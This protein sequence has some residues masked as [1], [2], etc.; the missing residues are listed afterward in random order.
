MKI[1]KSFFFILVSIYV[2]VNV[3]GTVFDIDTVVGLMDS[4]NDSFGI[5]KALNENGSDEKGVTCEHLNIKNCYNK[6]LSFY[7]N[8]YKN[9]ILGVFDK[10]IMAL[11]D[12]YNVLVIKLVSQYFKAENEIPIIDHIMFEDSM[13]FCVLGFFSGFNIDLNNKLTDYIFFTKLKMIVEVHKNN[14]KEIVEIHFKNR[15]YDE[16]LTGKTIALNTSFEN[17]TTT[18]LPELKKKINA[19]SKP[20]C[21]I[22]SLWINA[23]S[24]IWTKL[25]DTPIILTKIG[26][27]E[28]LLAWEDLMVADT[29]NISDPDS[30]MKYIYNYNWISVINLLDEDFSER[31]RDL[32]QYILDHT[33][34]DTRIDDSSTITHQPEPLKIHATTTGM[35]ESSTVTHKT[36]SPQD[37]LRPMPTDTVKS[38]TVTHETVFPVDQVMAHL[39]NNFNSDQLHSMKNKVNNQIMQFKI[40]MVNDENINNSKMRVPLI[41]IM[42]QKYNALEFSKIDEF[43]RTVS[44]SIDEYVTKV[45]FYRVLYILTDALESYHQSV[46]ES[47][48]FVIKK[49]IIGSIPFSLLSHVVDYFLYLRDLFTVFQTIWELYTSSEP[50]MLDQN[51][52]TDANKILNFARFEYFESIIRFN[53]SRETIDQIRKFLKDVR[54]HG[55]STHSAQEKSEPV[56][57]ARIA[58]E[59]IDINNYLMALVE[60]KRRN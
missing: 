5:G 28:G 45:L 56:D 29:E 4:L 6:L 9:T 38:L 15:N 27:F 53:V 16:S 54:F 21:D 17:I 7:E 11:L 2:I 12:E 33:K 13:V 35:A 19:F 47:Y 57:L 48:S 8:E 49:N 24:W 23:N 20:F 22:S 1:L 55:V 25:I 18:L 36:E 40:K 42:H 60:I 46:V 10:K 51:T 41:E 50:L 39:R 34:Q 30:G 26:N 14:L 44:N 3:K 43:Y 59:I 32:L 58:D 31:C 52:I 37:Q